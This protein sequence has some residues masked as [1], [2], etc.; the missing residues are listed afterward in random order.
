MKKYHL[1]TKEYDYEAHTWDGDRLTKPVVFTVLANNYTEAV[2]RTNN[3][4]KH[5]YVTII[6]H[7]RLKRYDLVKVRK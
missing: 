2:R 7:H 1:R 4:I 5:Q 3:W 6:P